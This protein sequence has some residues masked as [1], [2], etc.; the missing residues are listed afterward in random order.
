MPLTY[1]YI[2][3]DKLDNMP[4][5]GFSIKFVIKW[6]T[7][8]LYSE[9]IEIFHILGEILGRFWFSGGAISQKCPKNSFF[10]ETHVLRS[11]VIKKS[12]SHL[13][14]RIWPKIAPLSPTHDII[15]IL[16]SEGNDIKIKFKSKQ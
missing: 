8:C 3:E 6:D 5:F 15:R 14:L 9:K 2:F 1:S 11:K 13:I 10:A 4:R 7:T 12:G 16:C